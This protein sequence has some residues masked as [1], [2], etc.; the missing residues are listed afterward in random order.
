TKR[1]EA[2]SSLVVERVG[3]PFQSHGSVSAAEGAKHADSRDPRQHRRC[4]KHHPGH[5]DSS[6][7]ARS[8]RSRRRRSAVVSEDAEATSTV[9]RWGP[10]VWPAVHRRT[11][12]IPAPRAPTTR[13]RGANH[14]IRSM[15][16]L[17]GASR[18]HS[19]YE[20]E[21]PDLICSGVRPA[22][23]SSAMVVRICCANREGESATERFWQRSEEHTSEL[24]SRV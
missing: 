23:S 3:Q 6:A 8:A 15:P 12:A 16:R 19:P 4:Q 5:S 14:A 7:E 13:N 2:T 9:S 1:A 22:R 24:Q 20:A 17:G 10:T 18:I 21:N 11:A